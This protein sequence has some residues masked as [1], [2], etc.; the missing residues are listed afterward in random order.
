M[1]LQL[2]LK[3]IYIKP[4]DIST[5]NNTKINRKEQRSWEQIDAYMDPLFSCPSE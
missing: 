1:I 3:Y 2:T 5:E 4:C